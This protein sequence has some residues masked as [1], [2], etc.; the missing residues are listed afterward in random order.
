M[1]DAPEKWT[2]RTGARVLPPGLGV[3]NSVTKKL[4]QEGGGDDLRPTYYEDFSA[5]TLA[6]SARLRQPETAS[7]H[8]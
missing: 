5:D 1:E 3:F 7:V 8:T 4:I 6:P 2:P